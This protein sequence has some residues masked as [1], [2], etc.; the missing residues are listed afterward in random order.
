MPCTSAYVA[1]HRKRLNKRSKL[2]YY[3]KTAKLS[4]EI[5]H[6]YESEYGLDK[7][8]EWVKAHSLISKSELLKIKE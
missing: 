2:S 3:N 5:I 7:T 1:K 8:I 4:Y 6:K